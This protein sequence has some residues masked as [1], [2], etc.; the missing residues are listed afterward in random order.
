M[1][2]RNPGVIFSRIL[3]DSRRTILGYGIGLAVYGLYISVIYPFIRDIPDF[4]TFLASDMIKGFFGGGLDF[5]DFTTPDGMMGMFFFVFVPL[6][7]AVLAVLYGLGMTFTEEEQGTLDVLL[8]YPIPRWQVIVEKF[9]AFVVILVAVLALALVGLVL[10][11]V[12]TPELDIALGPLL[13]GMLNVIPVV[14]LTTALTLF[15]STVL[16]SR[17]AA[18][19]VVIALLVASYFMQSLAGMLSAPLNNMRYA[20]IFHYYGGA[21]VLVNGVD[22]SGFALLTGLTVVFLGLALV[23]FQRRDIAA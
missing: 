14:L 6:I 3:R 8:S 16:R 23:A 12:I 22:W 17:G 20:S 19:G 15:L 18:A 11:R 10:S 9:A 2:M 4:A 13:L 7:L 1:A 5:V 21:G